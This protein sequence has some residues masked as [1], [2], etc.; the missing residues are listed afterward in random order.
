MAAKISRLSVTATGY[1]KDAGIKKIKN[2][3]AASH[4]EHSFAGM[5]GKGIEPLLKPLGFDWRISTAL[6]SG[7]AAKEIVVST[8]ATIYSMGQSGEDT[9]GL[10]ARLRSDKAYNPAIAL[11][12]IIFVLL[13]VPCLAA[14]AVFHKEAG[15]LKITL[16]Y[17]AYAMVTAW[18]MA[19]LVYRV[20]LL[21]IH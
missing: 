10:A 7:I 18:V 6:V 5:I 12:L 21:F 2:E 17:I 15:E 4:L 13:Y 20:A 8:M 14:T 11:S 19:F 9:H 1:E 16:F 3:Y